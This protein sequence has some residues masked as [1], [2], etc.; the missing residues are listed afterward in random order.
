MTKPETNAVSVG[1]DVSDSA[2][3]STERTVEHFSFGKNW[4][5]FLSTLDEERIVSAERSLQKMLGVNSLAGSRFL[6]AGCG[7]GL[8]SLA[9][10]RLGAQVYSFDL[11]RACVACAG[12][13]RQRYFPG[14][15][16]WLIEEG[17]LL[18]PAYLQS[19]GHFDI[20]YSWGVL[21]HT[22][23]MWRALDQL[24]QLVRS[25]GQLFIAIYNDQGGAS[26]RWGLIKR[27]YN[28]SPRPVQLALVLA[29]GCA[30]E[31]RSAAIRL[32]R[33]QNPL[34]FADWAAKKKDRGMSVWHDLVD[35][36]GGWPFEVAKPH[37]VFDFLRIRG[38]TLTRL[39]TIGQGHGCNEYVFVKRPTPAWDDDRLMEG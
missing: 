6:D 24:S 30:W 29:V 27:L 35:W 3:A 31:V 17:S 9:A 2:L 13:L 15:Q 33:F 32:V 22:G 12:E 36:V 8:F 10:R 1:R 11:D 5:A 39:T 26:K 7:S 16:T 4:A 21:H 20:V 34:P 38:H 28:R 19:L 18:D 14:D 25:G 23:A 37:E